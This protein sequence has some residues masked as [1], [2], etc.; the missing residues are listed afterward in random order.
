MSEISTKAD[1]KL[2][3]TEMAAGSSC[4]AGGAGGAAGGA[5]GGCDAAEKEGSL[6]GAKY[7]FDSK[8]CPSSELAQPTP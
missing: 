8:L 2:K 3:P 5:A 1:G 7:K 4:C 6:I